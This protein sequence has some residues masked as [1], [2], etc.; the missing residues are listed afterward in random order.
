MAWRACHEGMPGGGR[1]G[2]SRA[3]DNPAD[4]SPEG[5][6]ARVGGVVRARGRATAGLMAA[7]RGP[8]S[9]RKALGRTLR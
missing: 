6:T 1:A 8:C 5:R 2:L 7:D 4:A 9:H 3:M